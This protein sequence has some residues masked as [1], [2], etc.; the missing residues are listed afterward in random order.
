MSSSKLYK[1]NPKSREPEE[2]PKPKQK[3]I[4]LDISGIPGRNIYH[5]FKTKTIQIQFVDTYKYIP[6]STTNQLYSA[7]NNNRQSKISTIHRNISIRRSTNKNFPYNNKQI[8]EKI[9][10]HTR[11]PK[12]YIQT[13]RKF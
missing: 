9:K 1:H 12:Q 13:H 7:L 10:K 6:S 11:K 8:R 5:S 3:R 4:I 2:E